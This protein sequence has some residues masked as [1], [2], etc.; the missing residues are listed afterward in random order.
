MTN[1]LLPLN[2]PSVNAYFDNNSRTII[3]HYK[4][5]LTAEVTQ[6]TYAWLFEC[7]ATYGVDQ[8]YAC[9]FDFTRVTKFKRDN[10]LASKKQTASAGVKFDVSR[11]PVG[12]LVKTQYQEQMVL[13]SQ[14]INHVDNRTK[15][16]RSE[17]QA[18][19]FF[20]QFHA[21]LPIKVD[22]DSA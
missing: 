3:V 7:L 20:E 16:V 18:L 9:I 2:D 10:T 15:I 5:T 4:N 13:L 21:D 19:A 14:A 12:L 1:K 11:I 6:K 17:A 8:V 22:K